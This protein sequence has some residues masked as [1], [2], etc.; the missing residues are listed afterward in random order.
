MSLY[1]FIKLQLLSI[2]KGL[3]I[4]KFDFW[5]LNNTTPVCEIKIDFSNIINSP[6]NAEISNEAF[7]C[8]ESKIYEKAKAILKDNGVTEIYL[9]IQ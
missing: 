4:I 7:L 2:Y 8:S 1:Y 6:R 9:E 5:L 3:A